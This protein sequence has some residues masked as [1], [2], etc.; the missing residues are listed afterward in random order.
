M[1]AKNFVADEI[2]NHPEQI[3][4][5]MADRQGFG[6]IA[7]DNHAL[8]KIFNAAES[9]LSGL[10]VSEV[11]GRNFFT[12]VAPCTA[13]RLFRGRFRQGIQDGTMD[14]HFYYTFTYRIRP[15]SAHIHMLYD[16]RKSPLFFIF[17]DRVIQLYEDL[18]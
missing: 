4:A 14:T 8:V 15:I 16:I 10:S 3:T 2:L 17:I 5:T 12:E 6:I 1:F 7:L 11:L 13:S 9:R 18:G